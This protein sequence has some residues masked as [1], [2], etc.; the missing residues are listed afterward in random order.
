LKQIPVFNPKTR[1]YEEG[2][3]SVKAG[4]VSWTS[5]EGIP[6]SFS[7]IADENG[8]RPTPLVQAPAPE[9]LALTKTAG[10]QTPLQYP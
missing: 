10:Y 6:F 3:G 9:A 8:Y 7:F 5:P 1:Q 2:I 4:V